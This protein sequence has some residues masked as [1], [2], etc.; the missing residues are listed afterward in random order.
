MKGWT[1][2]GWGGDRWE[3]GEHKPIVAHTPLLSYLSISVAHR[4]RRRS[5]EPPLDR[6]ATPVD[7]RR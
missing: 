4:R 2:D 3:H 5:S 6:G 1:N 7:R